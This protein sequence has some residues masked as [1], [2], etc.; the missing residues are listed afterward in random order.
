MQTATTTDLP[1]ATYCTW[2]S[3]RDKATNHGIPFHP[4]WSDFWVFLEDNGPCPEGSRFVCE[5]ETAGYVPGNSYWSHGGRF[6]RSYDDCAL[7]IRF[8]KTGVLSEANAIR[9][10]CLDADIEVVQNAV[11]ALDAETQHRAAVDRRKAFAVLVDTLESNYT[12][13]PF[14]EPTR[15]QIRAEA[16]RILDENMERDRERNP[17]MVQEEGDFDG[18]PRFVPIV[19]RYGSLW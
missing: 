14:G 1:I 9:L 13:V 4:A 18:D 15:W 2:Q 6:K 17:G 12:L 19:V 16:R 7:A 5:S 3:A 11:D 8:V 10:A